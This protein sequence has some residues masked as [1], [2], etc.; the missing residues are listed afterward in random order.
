[1][2]VMPSRVKYVQIEE[3]LTKS[4]SAACASC[5]SAVERIWASVLRGQR[6]VSIPVAGRMGFASAEKNIPGERVPA[7]TWLTSMLGRY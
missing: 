2:S 4:A 1:M 3:V 7:R 5:C 6:A